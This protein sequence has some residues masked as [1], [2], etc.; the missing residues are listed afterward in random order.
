[1]EPKH[2]YTIKWSQP[3]SFGVSMEE[4]DSMMEML[5]ELDME[6]GNMS[7]SKAVIDNIMS[8]K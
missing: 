7:E 8:K 4:L 3:Y 6:A 2:F 1:M 5:I